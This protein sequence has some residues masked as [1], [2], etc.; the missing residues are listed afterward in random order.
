MIYEGKPVKDVP[1]KQ[2]L[3]RMGMICIDRERRFKKHFEI[4]VT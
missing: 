4:K 1:Y 2:V 3:R